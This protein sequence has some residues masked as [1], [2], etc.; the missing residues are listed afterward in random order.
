MN[1]KFKA[2]LSALL[3]AAMLFGK[4]SVC[5]DDT[6]AAGTPKRQLVSD[7]LIIADF[8]NG[9]DGF[10]KGDNVKALETVTT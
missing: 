6:E 5:A 2:A 7:E 1:G 4:I 9:S 3:T 8:D 10:R